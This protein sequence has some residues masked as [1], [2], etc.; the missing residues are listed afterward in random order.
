MPALTKKK[1]KIIRIDNYNFDERFYRK[2]VDDGYVFNPSVTYMIQCAYPQGN[3]LAQWR[4]DV[5]NKRADEILEETGNDGS[6]VHECIEGILNGEEIKSEI[7]DKKFNP[8]RSLKVKRC[9]KS[10][11]DW[12]EEYQPTTIETE[13]II[14]VDPINLHV[15]AGHKVDFEECGR[16][17]EY[18]GFA[19]T[20]DYLCEIGG[21]TYL[22]DF[23]TSKA[24]Y[25]GHKVQIAAYGLAHQ[26]DHIGLLHLGNAT[27]KRYSFNILKDEDRY[28]FTEEFL[29]TNRLFKTLY[30]NACP[31]LETF[32]DIF[33]IKKEKDNESNTQNKAR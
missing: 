23:K 32:P 20:L 6:F 16:C 12:H 15:K 10:F 21:E 1:N 19:G 24:I 30:P 8:K 17:Q 25:P 29:Q 18:S 3:F 31:N 14:W 28:K 13:S 2:E 11:I 26:V 9:L 4:G 22:I 33:T 27:K 5:G 7:I